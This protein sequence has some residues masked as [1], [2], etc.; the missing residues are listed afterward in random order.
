MKTKLFTLIFAIVVVVTTGV[1]AL[2]QQVAPKVQRVR[3][4]LTN[5]GYRPA[6]FQLKKGIPARVTFIRKTEED[7]GK[8]VVIPAFGIRRDLPLNTPVTVRFVPKTS[9]TFGYACGM[10]MFR[11]KLIVR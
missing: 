11:G 10:D 1:G 3:V 9:G 7:C 5:A 8:E 2:A 6:S 4:E